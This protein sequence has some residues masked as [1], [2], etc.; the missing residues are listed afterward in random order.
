MIGNGSLLSSLTAVRG[1]EL[2]TLSILMKSVFSSLEERSALPT[3]LR[4]GSLTALQNLSH[5]PPLHG[6][7]SVM[8]HLHLIPLA[9]NSDLIR[10]CLD[11]KCSTA[12]S[13]VTLAGHT[14]S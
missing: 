10:S 14:T 12:T 8:N 3:T 1:L 2:I 9:D 5:H 4:S 11:P 7:G 13:S 6:E